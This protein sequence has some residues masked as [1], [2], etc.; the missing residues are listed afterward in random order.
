MEKRTISINILSSLILQFV[1]IISGFILPRI[2]LSSFGSE[3]N[4]LVS[5]LNQFL[6]YVSLLEG[7]VSG[8]ITA[9]LYRPL[10]EKNYKIISGIIKATQHFFNQIGIIF[11]IYMGLLGVIYPAVIKTGFSY[12]YVV[13][14]TFVLGSNL[15]VQY[16]L[17]LSYRLLLK[18]DGKIYYVSFVQTLCIAIN[19]ILVVISVK[20]FNDILLVKLTS[21]LVY[22]IQP[23][24]FRIYVKKNYPIDMNAAPDNDA[25]QQ[26]WDGFGQNLAF[27]IHSN[28]DIV[29]LTIFS[30]LPMVSVYSI[31]SMVVVS[32]KN[33]VVSVSTSIIPSMGK[34]IVGDKQED[35]DVAF[36][37]YEFGMYY[38]SSILFTCCLV[39]IVP[40][41]KIYTS[42]IDDANYIQPIFAMLLTLAEM[43]YC[44]RDPYISIVYIAG[45]FRDTSKYAVLEALTNIIISVVLVQKMG[46]VGIAIGTLAAMII[47]MV[48]HV[49]YLN[50]NVLHRSIRF[51]MKKIFVFGVATFF[52][53]NLASIAISEIDS[54]FSWA[55]NGIYVFLIVFC[56][57]T[58]F[59][60]IFFK[61]NISLIIGNKS[62]RKAI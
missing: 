3:T 10:K 34:V 62:K 7:G 39:L 24:M 29:V 4:G 33:L 31:Y 19:I 52:S 40:F 50:S 35:T 37:L 21:A 27:F 20:L 38:I 25:L 8:V 1:T 14:L 17:S 41:V 57:I 23:L 42:S 47:R 30:T 11:L 49:S 59:S 32:L 45:K 28:T 18:T 22:L 26:R 61:E 43:V 16:F 48:M 5:S 56:I 15:L 54:L 44:I 2:I 6:N 36:E 55:I 58:I 9:S 51:F 12:I 46:L 53:F 13:L 60:L